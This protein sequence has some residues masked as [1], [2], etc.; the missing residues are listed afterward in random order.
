[1]HVFSFENSS[2]PVNPYSD[3]VVIFLGLDAPEAAAIDDAYVNWTASH[4]PPPAT[5]IIGAADVM[6]EFHTRSLD[7][8]G[9]L[10]GL[11]RLYGFDAG[12][13][14]G[15]AGFDFTGSVLQIS[16]DESDGFDLTK[17][18]FNIVS[19]HVA[20]QIEETDIIIPAPPGTFF[21][22]LS[23][24][25]SSHF[26]RAEALLQSTTF[27]EILAL[28]L[29]KPFHEW[30][31]RS[32][33]KDTATVS[34]FLDTMSV[35]PVAEKLSQLHQLGNPTSIRHRIESFKSYDGLSMWNPPRRPAFVIISAS[36]SGG[37]E[38]KVVGKI[39]VSNAEVWT[40]LSLAPSAGGSTDL[41]CREGKY[42]AQIQRKLKGRPALD[43]LRDEFQSDIATIPPGTE[44]I[45]IVGERFLSQPAKPK[46]VRLVHKN[47]DDATKRTLVAIARKHVVK[48]GRGRFDARSRWSISFD[49]P[50]LLEMACTPERPGDDSLLKSWLKNY[51]SPGPVAVVY[52]SAA[53]PSATQVS[54]SAAELAQRTVDI[55]KELTPSASVF[56]LSSEEL[57]KSSQP[58]QHDLKHCSII[59]VAPVVG[60]GFILKQISALLRHKQP[61]GPRLFL[62]LAV[63]PESQ[64]HLTQLKSDIAS[65]ATSDS[66]YEFKHLFALPIGRLD[67]A[68]QWTIE[69]E[70]LRELDELMAERNIRA[71]VVTKRT[72]LLEDYATLED[73]SV[74]LPSAQEKPLPLSTGFF[75]WPG[76]AEIEGEN[77]GGAVLLSIA[78]LLQ[79][80]RTAASQSDDTSLRTGLFQHAL[81]CPETF[82]RFNDPVIQA[83]ILR[84]AYS[85][86]LNY[87]VSPEMSHDMGR[88][89]LKW[90]Q[91][92]NEPA[93]AAAG[94][95]LLA[96]A[97]G[98]LKLRKGDTQS[99]LDYAKT[100]S[101]W[102]GCLA[103][104]AEARVIKPA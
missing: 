50:A 5:L 89:L 77:F 96:I 10:A 62:A 70:V 87:G 95:F 45:S 6:R 36:T 22:K 23:A 90:L 72:A 101:G 52:P 27:I 44:T 14:V 26:I 13:V 20:Q 17:L 30:Y 82:T 83:A 48:V 35:W 15:L 53:G 68:V 32:L 51:S 3:C 1:M 21:D 93:G 29:L 28:R 75:L 86:E 25:F 54:Q 74:F 59:V 12:N 55:L 34:I 80:A 8:K 84:A 97:T 69:I 16:T 64:A 81:I 11:D 4:V 71:P 57:A 91:Y 38:G 73:K 49:F 61:T 65:V 102:I 33:I 47:L 2:I 41:T 37:L 76:S 100:R 18:F 9:K 31:A 43:G 56:T 79:A 58:F 24:R 7:R 63:L 103:V 94:E 99:V 39:G 78:A 60:N 98:K 40:L 88:L 104:V 42:I 19:E 67:T 92:Y 46:R 85:S 66:R